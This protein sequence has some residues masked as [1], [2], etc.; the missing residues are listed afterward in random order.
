MY[1]CLSRPVNTSSQMWKGEAAFARKSTTAKTKQP[2]QKNSEILIGFIV[3]D[4]AHYNTVKG[5]ITFHLFKRLFD[6]VEFSKRL[7]YY[8]TDASQVS[9]NQRDG[10]RKKKLC[11][12]IRYRCLK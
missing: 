9:G 7:L 11:A 4:K 12:V 3:K 1:P 8:S 6:V 5:R 2:S 10:E